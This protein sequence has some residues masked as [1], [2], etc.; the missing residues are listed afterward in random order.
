VAQLYGLMVEAVRGA[1]VLRYV[2]TAGV[3]AHYVGDACRP[4][5]ASEVLAGVN[6]ALADHP[7]GPPKVTGSD[8]AA[9]AA[10][11]L[12]QRTIDAIPPADIVAVF[13]VDP[14]PG[15]T[16]QLWNTFGAATISRLAAGAKTV[17]MLW[18][19]ACERAAVKRSTPPRSSRCRSPRCKS[20]TPQPISRPACGSR[21]GTPCRGP[22]RPIAAGH[23]WV[24]LPPT[25]STCRWIHPLVP[26]HVHREQF[27]P[28]ATASCRAG[29]TGDARQF[30]VVA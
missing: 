23:R 26:R 28:P 25:V 20:S 21:T 6:T 3:L 30:Q 22:D 7:P 14:G 5:H 29:R 10:V 17:A 27:C 11:A 16:D 19:A 1:E 8:E 18:N 4:L 13:T 9:D 15:R 12:M 24:R 2:A